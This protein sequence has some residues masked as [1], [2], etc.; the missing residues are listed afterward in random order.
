MIADRAGRPAVNYLVRMLRLD[1]T[2]IPTLPTPRLVLR[3]LDEQDAP[4]IFELRS[5]PAVMRYIPKPLDGRIE[6]S[7]RMIRDFRH[8]AAR[9]DSILWGITVKGSSTVLGY[10]GFWRIL[11]EHHRAEIG[12]ALHPGLWGQGLMGEA[13]AATMHH[14]FHVM[15]L[16]SVEASVTPDNTASIHVLERAGFRKEGYF[17][18]NF[19]S[20]GVF[21][22]SV[23]YS[24]LT[25]L[26]PEP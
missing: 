6:E 20:N 14:G 1:L 18:E 23:V 22:D 17:K 12:Y 3:A 13:V 4:A 26:H 24:R 8:A 2:H 16:H 5:D 10:I 15:R 11:H 19:R 9:G 7:L 25:P 21:L